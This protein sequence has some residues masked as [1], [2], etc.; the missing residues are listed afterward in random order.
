MASKPTAKQLE[1]TSI[2]A[3]ELETPRTSNILKQGAAGFTD[4]FTGLPAIAGFAGAGIE[5]AGKSLLN[6]GSG[7]LE[8]FGT[9]LESGTDL[10][11]LNTA[12]RWRGYVNEALGIEEP[13]STEDQ[14]TRLLTSMIFPGSLGTSTLGKVATFLTP[15]VR[16]GPKGA[17]FGKGF[18]L[19]AGTQLGVGAGIEQGIRAGLTGQPLLFSEEALSG[20]VVPSDKT[21]DDP[22]GISRRRVGRLTAE[23]LETPPSETTVGVP[24]ARATFSAEELEGLDIDLQAADRASQ[25]AEDQNTMKNI[26]L[27]GA[28]AAS[29][30]GVVKWKQMRAIARQ[31]PIP[32][33]TER[34]SVASGLKNAMNVIGAQNTLGGKV[35]AAKLLA[36]DKLSLIGANRFSANGHIIRALRNANASEDTI[37]QIG[38][39]DIFDTPGQLMEFLESGILANGSRVS[40]PL[41]RLKRTF[42]NWK[43]ERQQEFVNYTSALTQDAIRVRATARDFLEKADFEK[44]G[45]AGPQFGPHGRPRLSVGQEALVTISGSF[46]KKRGF[47]GSLDELD[48]ALRRDEWAEII[49][50]V[51]GTDIRTRPGLWTSVKNKAGKEIRKDFVE[52]DEL[53]RRIKAGDKDAE[54][55]EMQKY[56]TEQNAAVLKM[57]VD[58]GVNSKAWADS[59]TRQFAR[60]GRLLYLPG[61]EAADTGIWYQRLSVNM[62]LFTSQGKVLNRVGN[63]Y[64]QSLKE[65]EGIGAQLDPFQSTAHY[66]G[67][68]ME[69]TNKSVAQ[70][71]IMEQ[72]TGIRIRPNGEVV[73]NAPN[74]NPNRIGAMESPRYVGKVS[75]ND[76]NN[77]FGRLNVAF[78]Q[79]DDPV[80]KALEGKFI[81]QIRKNL[82]KDDPGVSQPFP[83]QLAMLDD[84]LVIQRNGD[85]YIFSEFGKGLRS[86]LEFDSALHGGI[87]INHSN[88]WKRVMTTFT[89]GK[90]SLFGPIS[91]LYNQQLSALNAA[92]RAEGGFAKASAEGIQVWKDGM[93]GSWDMFATKVADDYAQILTHALENNSGIAKIAPAWTKNMQKMFAKR[94]KDNMMAPIQRQVGKFNSGIN[95]S[96]Y[97]GNINDVLDQSAFYISKRFGGNTL[98]QFVRIW[99]HL[100]DAMHEGTAF[101]VTLRKLGGR[102]G[103]HKTTAGQ[104]RMARK[105]ASDIVGDVRLKGSEMAAFNA[106]VPFS[107]AMFQAWSTLGRAVAK[108]GFGR[109]LATL[110]TAVGLPT[111]LEV[112]YNSTLDPEAKF[113]DAENNEWTY[114][115]YY[116]RG[117]T[118]DQR[119]NNMIIMIPGKPPWEAILIPIVPELSLFRGAV[120]DGMDIAMGMSTHLVTEGNHMVGGLIRMF[121]IPLPPPVKAVLSGL[122]IDVRAGP[123]VDEADG[124]G[125][126][127]FETR[128]LPT[129]ERVTP[130]LGRTRFVGGEI[131]TR[132]HAIL[133][134]LFGAGGTLSTS[135]F[136]AVNSGDEQTPLADRV[137]AGFDQLGKSLAQQARYI[138]PLYGKTLRN[139]P[140]SEVA[141]RVVHKKDAIESFMK[142]LNIQKSKGMMS[143][144]IPALGQTINVSQD[145]ILQQLAANAPAYKALIQPH[146]E[147]ISDLR[148]QIN[149][150]GT[151]LYIN[152]PVGDIPIGPIT[153]EQ[154]DNIIDAINLTIDAQNHV[155]LSILKEEEQTFAEE[156]GRTIG[157]DLTGF[158]F[159]SVGTGRT[160]PRSISPVPQTLPQTSR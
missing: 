128:N 79:Y 104:I 122:G 144:R 31:G 103:I 155:I 145:P 152:Q 3:E 56:L 18:A 151:A 38:G 7:F 53:F 42:D 63:F 160:N 80:G 37:R 74:I 134:D 91:G 102:A 142:E 101:G 28:A 117:F 41:R 116:W 108:A 67:E 127:F 125:I 123:T 132:L 112:T 78:H 65:G 40:V 48:A 154:R 109:T 14:A 90:G 59:I 17:R 11:L 33:G 58:R 114:N 73:I 32:T 120:I 130:G 82:P 25:A 16:M 94:A 27:I 139:H 12:A 124:S 36:K 70:W 35:S 57:S 86:S 157:R 97:T 6:N 107:G 115:S 150:L 20:G 55:K 34:R 39:Q 69:H 5:A 158:T 72:L 159:E 8:N 13:V 106:V 129:G 89:T 46:A 44:L 23:E 111:A 76:P 49:S 4:I 68:V 110:V 52:D 88:F 9:A 51:R 66:L 61:K 136:E 21:E 30:F 87:V 75:P 45:E 147:I 54:F 85:F 24:T 153:I 113:K 100:N 105:Y 119:N 19:R 43:P 98:P 118:V 60:N 2:P 96:E 93:A 47:T 83:E 15:L 77:Q 131:E 99:G 126:S 95:K 92:L 81:S 135:V 29:I 133:Q 148:N 22:W 62:G 84:A 137:R 71:N 143:G 146:V 121:N 50:N 138:N 10:E 26:A 1:G 149:T 140:D 64:K 141:R 156:F